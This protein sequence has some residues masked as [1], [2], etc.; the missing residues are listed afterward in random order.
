MDEYD[1][2]TLYP[3]HPMTKSVKCINQTYDE[4][5]SMDIFQ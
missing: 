4:D 3:M 1:R 2:K 5:F